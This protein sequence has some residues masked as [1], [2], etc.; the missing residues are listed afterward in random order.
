[1]VLQHMNRPSVVAAVVCIIFLSSLVLIPLANADWTMYHAD[2]S[3]NGVATGTSVLT[4]KLLWNFTADG[5]ITSSPAMVNGVVYIGSDAGNLYALKAANG[6]KIWNYTTLNS[7][8]SSPAVANGLVYVGSDDGNLY[9]LNAV[10]GD[11]AW[12]YSI[13]NNNEVLSSPTVVDG[14][15]YVGSF[16]FKIGAPVDF[17]G[18]VYAFNAVNGAKLWNFTTGGGI[19]SSPAVVNGVVYIGSEDDNVYALNATNGDELWSYTTGNSLIRLLRWS[20]A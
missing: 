1:M 4:P 13:G 11:Q 10:N 17:F 9:A 15:V 8:E 16:I 12:N 2:P 18:Y 20:T 14:V 6:A 19:F 5:T 7:I 3:H